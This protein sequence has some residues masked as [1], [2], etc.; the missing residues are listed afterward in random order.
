MNKILVFSLCAGLFLFNNHPVSAQQP[1]AEQKPKPRE[2]SLDTNHDGKVDR[3][4]VYDEKGVITRVEASTNN[5]GKMNEK[6][7]FEN[8]VR[9]RAERDADGNGQTDTI[10]T[11]D[12]NG[13]ITK[14]EADTAGKGKMNE[15][16]YYE[17]GAPAK[18]EKD[19]ND[20]GKPDTWI[21]Y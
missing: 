1:Q 6:V 11:Y 9:V 15:W 10:V 18:A 19:T 5:D 12:A 2:I 20:D 14:I 21:K 7:F 4:E 13:K 17:N 8:G 16:V 3:L